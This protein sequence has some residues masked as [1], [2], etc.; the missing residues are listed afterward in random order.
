[1]IW[2]DING[3]EGLYKISSNGD[4]LSLNFNGKRIKRIMN[5]SFDKDGYRYVDLSKD[6][7]KR[8]Y[9]VHRLVAINFISNPNN[10]P[11]INH[12][13]ENKQNNCVENLEWCDVLYNNNYGN[14]KNKIYKPILQY[15]LE[16][17]LVKRWKSAKE[18]SDSLGIFSTHITKCAKE[19]SK[20]S[21]GFIWKY[22]VKLD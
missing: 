19:K 14:R 1:M 4:V 22:D 3:F 16:M 5:G 6:K 9:K 11:C 15:D 18:A 13:D 20:S 8:K 2:K 10:Y 7:F 17:N 21:H 12:K